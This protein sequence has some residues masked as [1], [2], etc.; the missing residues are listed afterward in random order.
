MTPTPSPTP[1]PFKATISCT[2]TEYDHDGPEIYVRVICH[3]TV[4]GAYDH[5]EFRENDVLIGDFIDMLDFNHPGNFPTPP[6]AL[7]I[8]MEF[9][10]CK[11]SVCTSDVVNLTVAPPDVQIQCSA[12][13]SPVTPGPPTSVNN[14]T[15]LISVSCT[16][17]ITGPSNSSQWY[18][19]N[20]ANGDYTNTTSYSSAN[21]HVRP[22][23]NFSIP[24]DFRACN[25][26][27][28]T[29]RSAVISVTASGNSV[30]YP[31]PTP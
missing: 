2:A 15:I 26:S 5:T 20:Q 28:C 4:V 11:G 31:A 8:K 12:V 16:A 18:E 25:V 9:K 21:S 13:R 24:I 23:P 3:G 14:G 19:N 17:T 10:A 29:T 22:P 7:V 27:L 30:A 1:I 6:P